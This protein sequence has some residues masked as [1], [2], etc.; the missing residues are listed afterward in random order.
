MKRAADI[1]A[2]VASLALLAYTGAR[3]A[4][5]SFTHDEALTWL[6]HVRA[7]LGEILGF[8]GFLPTNNHLL[9]T[10]LAKL[11]SSILGPS[12]FALRLPNVAAHAMY[13]FC[14]WR[15]LRRFVAPADALAAFAVLNTQP[16]LL[17]FFSLC[18]GY[19][20]SLAFLMAGLDSL[21]D[22]KREW[23]GF[24][25]LALGV[26]SAF[27]LVNAFAGALLLALFLRR[28]WRAGLVV[29]AALSAYVLPVIWKLRRDLDFGGT[30]GFWHDTAGSLW[31]CLAYNVSWP[32][33][34]ALAGVI[35]GFFVRQPPPP[36]KL[37]AAF[38]LVLC[39]AAIAEEATH[40][41]AH[42]LF[43]TDRMAAFY[44]PLLAL[45]LVFAL[46]R[47]LLFGLAVLSLAHFAPSVNLRSSYLWAYDAND[48]QVV[49]DLPRRPLRLGVTWIFSPAL[50]YYRQSRGLDWLAPVTRDGPFGDYDYV[51]VAPGDRAGVERLG[52]V[53]VKEYDGNALYRRVESH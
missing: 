45:V 3:A 22:E 12:E 29:G 38:A 21:T 37:A 2:L 11:T 48:K 41:V 25:F 33:Y 31:P 7:P 27:S 18:R 39:G 53:L 14:G 13:L 17:D 1:A 28:N 23:R 42:T 15:L 6:L 47:P 4:M 34:I 16:F 19:G 44:L 32:L 40:L 9:N 26:L 8:G 52:L 10:L 35:G 51:Y 30:V 50:E 24:V 36:R 49:A 46:P 5:L 43:L 20:L